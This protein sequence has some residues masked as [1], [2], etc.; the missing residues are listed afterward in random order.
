MSTFF[1]SKLLKY[2]LTNLEINSEEPQFIGENPNIFYISKL[3]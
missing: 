2:G 1:S 3:I